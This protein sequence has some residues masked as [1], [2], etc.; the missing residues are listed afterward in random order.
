M[1]AELRIADKAL[2]LSS[3]CFGKVCHRVEVSPLPY[4]YLLW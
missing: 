3:V 1:A 2:T 4:G